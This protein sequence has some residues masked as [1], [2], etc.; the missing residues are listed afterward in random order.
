MWLLLQNSV[1]LPRERSNEP[2]KKVEFAFE[3]KAYNLDV[4]F[5]KNDTTKKKAVTTG[6]HEVTY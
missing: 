2:G 5:Y 4:D 1:K 6:I 3:I